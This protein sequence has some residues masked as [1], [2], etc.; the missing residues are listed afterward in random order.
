MLPTAGDERL[1]RAPL[2]A[3]RMAPGDVTPVTAGEASDIHR[4]DVGMIDVPDYGAVYLI[5]A[6][7]PAVVD[8]GTGANY[9]RILDGLAGLGVGPA[10]LAG[11]VLTHVHLDHA[12]GAGYLLRECPNADVYVHERGARQLVDPGQLW[13][14]TRQVVEGWVE[15]YAE[16]APVPASRLV[17]LG[18]GGAV[19]LGDRELAVH[20]APG[21]AP[22]QV[23]YADPASDCVFTGDAAGLY[24]PGFDAPRPSTP[25]PTFELAQ[26]LADLDVLRDLDPAGLCFSHADAA[27][28]DDLLAAHAAVLEDWVATVEAA[29]DAAGT[30]DLDAVVDELDRW[31]DAE[32][33]WGARHVRE[34]Q[35]LNVRGVLAAGG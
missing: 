12:G 16:P 8:T 6:D 32:A 24:V 27:P 35:R 26:C 19:D 7:R 11:V 33:V 17:E 31:P 34:T 1:K 15:Y 28:T 9:E 29:R 21:H 25:P 20:E 23:V 14:G 13:A 5:D 3:S 4:L 2:R 30:D 22:H 10:D 18:D